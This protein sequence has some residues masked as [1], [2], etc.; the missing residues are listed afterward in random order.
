MSARIAYYRTSARDQSIESQR[1]A[2]G[3]QFDKEFKDEGV[4]GAV[5]AADRPGFAALLAYAREGDTVCV[6]AVDRLGRDAID[7]QQTVR[8]LMAKGVTIDVRGMGPIVSGIVGQIVL[9]L[10]SQI[11]EM[12]RERINE[13]TRNGRERA[14][15]LL[16]TTGKTQHGATS[17]GR[18][19]KVVPDVIA[20]WRKA[21]GA[22]IKDT[23]LHFDV[24]VATV[25]RA[26]AG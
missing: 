13:R 19:V 8:A 24:S 10:L 18:P 16:A 12:E 4:S 5:P 23:A 7:V 15:E 14:K 25:K 1:A 9:T 11:A 6:Y 22:S 17:M 2:M 26:C 3:G 21:N 20:S